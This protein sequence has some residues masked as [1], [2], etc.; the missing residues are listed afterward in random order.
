MNKEIEQ[1]IKNLMFKEIKKLKIYAIN[2]HNYKKKIQFN[3]IDIQNINNSIEDKSKK[4]NINSIMREHNY[5][6]TLPIL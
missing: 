1:E 2:Y 5:A 6:K 4:S 3:D